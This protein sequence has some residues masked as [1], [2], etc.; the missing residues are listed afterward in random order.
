MKKEKPPTKQHIELYL[1]ISPLLI[2]KKIYTFIL[3]FDTYFMDKN[4]NLPWL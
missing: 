1:K 3:T 4:G 2:Q